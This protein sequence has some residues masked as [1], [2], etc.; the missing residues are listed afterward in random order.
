[1]K[2]R[3]ISGYA[4][5]SSEPKK[6]PRERPGAE[7]RGEW[8]WRGVRYLAAIG[9]GYMLGLAAGRMGGESPGWPIIVAVAAVALFLI[10][11]QGQKSV[12]HAAADAISA[13][14]ARANAAAQA[15]SQN[16]ITVAGGHVVQGAQRF[17]PRTDEASWLDAASEREE[18]GA[19]DYEQPPDW[20]GWSYFATHDG[21]RLYRHHSSGAI[22]S[23]SELPEGARQSIA[24]A[25]L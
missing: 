6:E 1:M 9:C 10:F 4:G 11:R 12:S 15:V 13:A 24:R 18:L 20:H 8:F 23:G 14:N 16:Q 2:I 21:V 17:D 22:R 19:V 7:Q 5:E 25:A 3:D